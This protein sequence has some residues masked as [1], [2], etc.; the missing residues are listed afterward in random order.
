MESFKLIRLLGEGGF[1]KTFLAQVLDERLK[2]ETGEFIAL[3]L[4]LNKEREEGLVKELITNALFNLKLRG[5]KHPNVV[6]YLGFSRFK[7]H[8][9]MMMEY[10]EGKSLRQELSEKK[11]LSVDSALA[12][13]EGILSGLAYAHKVGLIHR[14]IN[15]SNILIKSDGVAKLTDFGISNILGDTESRYGR[16]GTGTF[17]YMPKECVK[18]GYKEGFYSD[19]YSFGA[20]L[21]EMVTGRLPFVGMSGMEIKNMILYQQPAPPI[22]LNPEVGERLSAIILASLAKEP[23]Q[24]FQTAEEFLGFIKEYRENEKDIDRYMNR[25]EEKKEPP[26]KRMF[27]PTGG[28][29][30]EEQVI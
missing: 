17:A 15:P 19:T 23:E 6:S 4:P 25:M 26:K 18:K 22:F 10:V 30:E 27:V 1:G 7:E 21:Y 24:R 8:Y 12:I 5:I 9:G 28:W 29:G 2:S 20:T 11:I 14:D 13:A 3:K 16:M